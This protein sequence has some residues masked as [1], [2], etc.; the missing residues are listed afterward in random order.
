[1]RASSVVNCQCT[2]LPKAMRARTQASISARSSAALVGVAPLN[3]DSGQLQGK[4]RIWGGRACVRRILYMATLPAIRHNPAIRTSMSVCAT[5]ANPGKC[6]RGRHAQAAHRPERRDAGPGAMATR[7]CH[8]AD[9]YLT[10]N[11]VT[12]WGL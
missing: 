4:R 11:T 8:Q 3:Q 7:T 6:P 9:P 10:F 1:M 5:R 12:A 2:G